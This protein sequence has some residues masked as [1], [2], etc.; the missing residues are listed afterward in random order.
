MQQFCSRNNIPRIDDQT[1]DEAVSR[2]TDMV[3]NVKE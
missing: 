3:G 1:L 2:A